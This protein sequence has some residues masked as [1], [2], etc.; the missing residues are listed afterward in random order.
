MIRA[1]DHV[2]ARPI[3]AVARALVKHHELLLGSMR[4]DTGW[5]ERKYGDLKEES[6]LDT[7]FPDLG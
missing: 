2:S 1:N 5:N 4:C 6:Q 7:S 3:V